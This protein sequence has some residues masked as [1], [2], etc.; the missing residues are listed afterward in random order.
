MASNPYVNKVYKADGTKIIDIS[1]STIDEESVLEGHVGYDAAGRRF[2]GT[3]TGGAG[4]NYNV[5][6]LDT[7]DG[8]QEIQITDAQG[9]TEIEEL[10]VTENGTY[11]A[12]AGAAYNPVY[13]N[14]PEGPDVEELNISQNGTY[15]AESGVAYNPVNVNVPTGPA[16]SASDVTVD[17]ANV[18]V[19][20]G[21]Y[22][23]QVVK[24]VASGSASTPATTKQQSAPTFSISGNVV[25][26]N[27]AATYVDVTP[28][29]TP[30]YISSGTS[31][32]I[33]MSANSNTYTLPTY[34]GS[35]V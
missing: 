27:V 14:V 29:V 15:T 7:G 28:N 24:T 20:A 33:T 22:S 26:A 21:L 17:G 8:T 23:A 11:N 13:V 9:G 10:H 18:T 32:R 16:K 1:D 4:G 19:P 3:A 30:G 6:S 34:D 25:T 12:G 2:E 31:G 35:V 5:I